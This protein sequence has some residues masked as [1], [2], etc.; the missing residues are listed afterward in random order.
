MF[1]FRIRP[2]MWWM[3]E[4]LPSSNRFRKIS[5]LFKEA[6]LLACQVGSD[7]SFFF[8]NHM[9]TPGS[10][11][12]IILQSNIHQFIFKQAVANCFEEM[13]FFPPS[14]LDSSRMHCFSDGPTHFYCNPLVIFVL[15]T[16]SISDVLSSLPLLERSQ[17][18]RT[19]T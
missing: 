8:F 17:S 11:L 19:S 10:T 4:P 13:D 6:N 7:V 1:K 5:I 12:Y 9:P 18:Q 3:H 16:A 14:S 15:L 2:I